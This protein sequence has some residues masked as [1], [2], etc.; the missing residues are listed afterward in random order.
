MHIREGVTVRLA[1]IQSTGARTSEV[2]LNSNGLVY[3]FSHRGSG[4]VSQGVSLVSGLRG[5]PERTIDAEGLSCDEGRPG[6]G[7]K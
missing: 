7:E 5:G 1:S 4:W 6:G 2:R 3:G